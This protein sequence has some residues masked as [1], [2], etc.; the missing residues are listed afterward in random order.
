MADTVYFATNRQAT[1]S[2]ADP[3]S[4]GTGMLPRG[5]L[6]LGRA[7]VAA[8]DFTDDTSGA[9]TDLEITDWTDPQSNSFHD[10]WAGGR[11][12]VVFIH[13]F[14]NSFSDAI[15]RAAFNRAFL[16]E[17]RYDANIIVFSW[18]SDGRVFSAGVPW[19]HYLDDQ[20]VAIASAGH[21]TMF[22][23]LLAAQLPQRRAAGQGTHLLCHSMGNRALAGTVEGLLAQGQLPPTMFDTAILAA[24]DEPSDSFAHAPKRLSGLRQLATRIGLLYSHDDLVLRFLSDPINN[25]VG[26]FFLDR[27]G[28]AGP[29]DMS[30]PVQFPPD[31]YD[32]LDVTPFGDWRKGD[33]ADDFQRSHQYYRLSATVR[34][35]LLG[36]LQGL[37]FDGSAWGN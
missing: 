11:P 34:G 26:A 14:A 4:Y 25:G 2:P 29:D 37:R 28:A 19:Q 12:I 10:L 8:P 30:D 6:T 3:A 21:I 33:L 1:G 17:G 18:P 23:R 20:G 22:L 24:A 16:V 36:F 9:I 13:G 15:S 31:R 35:R 27:L 7:F 5:D 32:F